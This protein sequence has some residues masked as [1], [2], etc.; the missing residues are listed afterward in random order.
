MP[1]KRNVAV[2]RETM[3]GLA[4]GLDVIRAFGREASALT[5]S[6]VAGAERIPASTARRCLH[7]LEDLGYVMRSGR[8]PHA[9]RWAPT[10]NDVTKGTSVFA[11]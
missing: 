6:D 10:P 8:T 11:S 9:S 3:N 1:A 7:T 4:K 2:R 5:L